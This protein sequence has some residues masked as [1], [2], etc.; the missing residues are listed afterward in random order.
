MKFT[1][2]ER[3]CPTPISGL[4]GYC[5]G[6]KYAVN[7]T[8]ITKD[9]LPYIYKMGELHFS[10]V[11]EEDWE[12][13][14]LKMKAGGIEIVASYLFWNHHE[15]IEG[16]FVFDGN[17]NVRAFCELCRRF[18]MP[19]F[20][21]IGPWAHGE[22]RN[23]GFPD[24]LI[25]KCGG[26]KH[27]R[28]NERPYLDYT[29]R[30][31][32]RV[33]DEV[34]DMSDVIIG[35]QVENELSGLPEHI[36]YLKSYLLKLGFNPPLWSATAWGGGGFTANVPKEGFLPMYGG[37]PEAPWS[38]KLTPLLDTDTYFFRDERGS[39]GIGNDLLGDYNAVQES[40]YIFPYL[41]C[42]LGGGN[43][44]TYHRRP[45]ITA[46]DISAITLC[47]LGSGVNGLGFYM[48]HGGKNPMGKVN[49]LQETRAAGNTN[50]Y[51]I[52]SYDFQSPLGEC[53][54]I[55]ESYFRLKSIFD[56]ISA[57]GVELASMPT[58]LP[59]ERPADLSDLSTPRMSV[60]SNGKRG[61]LFINN[62]VHAA[63][64]PPFSESITV[65][66]PEK[67][68]ELGLDI[69][70]DAMGII[71]LFFPIGSEVA[72]YVTAMPVYVTESEIVFEANKGIKPLICLE[73]GSILPLTGS[74]ELGGVTV[75]LREPVIPES[76]TLIPVKLTERESALPLS[77][78]AHITNRD[79]TPIA[80]AESRE[81]VLEVP[82][83]AKYL[84]T[85]AKG[86]VGA[87]YH[88]D[89]LFDDFYLY[90]DR[91][92]TDIRGR[93]NSTEIILKILPLCEENKE[94]IYFETDM[95]VGGATPAVYAVMSEEIG[96]IER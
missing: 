50:D 89:G 30:Y 93:N 75:T 18:N 19:F 2:T 46:D 5:L 74:A 57:C 47:S 11:P 24:W 92:V 86:N 45:L 58:F 87:M 62:H 51:P 90:G 61:F 49:T 4:G 29:E 3:G 52:F 55:R 59:D 22:A 76:A 72:R 64:M 96:Y 60:R 82:E 44:V 14:L 34:K 23:G 66:L 48:Y 54:Q 78:F 69:D 31:F 63:H 16:E 28:K 8:Y 80:A 6:H 35:I 9:G 13:E 81:Y 17:C 39:V 71:P 7:D 79:G 68:I 12:R 85:E 43:Q 40:G 20:L 32:S 88:G 77:A 67:K 70:S 53:G 33:Y 37:Y 56:F 25:E 26:M 42:E 15:E 1:V 73:D 38:S 10:R 91:W 94:K 36:E 95:P 27:T 83:K 65:E 21:R 84:V 41:T